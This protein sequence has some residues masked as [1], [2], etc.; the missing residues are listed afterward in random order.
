M[1]RRAQP[2]ALGEAI[3]RVR[4]ETS[5]ATPLAAAQAVWRDAVGERIAAHARPLRE[6]DG[7]LTVGCEAATWAQELDL[8]SGELLARVNAALGATPLRGLRFVVDAEDDSH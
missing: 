1:T 2:R 5:P 7:V 8:L 6:R 4:S 3:R